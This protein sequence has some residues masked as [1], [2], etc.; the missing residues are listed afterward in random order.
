MAVNFVINKTYK[1]ETLAPSILGASYTNMKLLEVKVGKQ[2]TE[3]DIATRHKHLRP[4][5]PNLPVDPSN[6]LF[7]KF[8]DLNSKQYIV[9]PME[10]IH[11]DS[12]EEIQTNN[13]QIRIP[14]ITTDDI[15]IIRQTLAELGY[16]NC[17]ISHY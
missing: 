8:Q 12:I 2:V 4:T 15:E 11:T 3:Y 10:Y 5:I 9:M 14:N 6:M 16:T 17:E 1:F 7:Y 13:L